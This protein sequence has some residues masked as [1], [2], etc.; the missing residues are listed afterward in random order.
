MSP[1]KAMEEVVRIIGSKAEVARK[2]DVKAPTVSQ[3]CSGERPVPAKRALELEK[4]SGGLVSKAALCPG[5]PW[6]QLAS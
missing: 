5:F 2:L 3:W 1:T 6:Q 4:L